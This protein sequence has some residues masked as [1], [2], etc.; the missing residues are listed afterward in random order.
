MKQIFVYKRWGEREED[1]DDDIYSPSIK[2]GDQDDVSICY[3]NNKKEA[4]DKFSRYF[5][6][7]EN[8]VYSLDELRFLDDDVSL[9]TPY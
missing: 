6:S 7:I 8:N 3:A 5:N 1:K 2:K 9:L 4:I